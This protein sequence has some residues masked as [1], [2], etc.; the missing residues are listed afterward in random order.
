MPKV[1]VIVPVYKV[2]KTLERCVE[3]VRNQ[4]LKDIEILLVDDGSPDDCPRM[5]DSFAAADARIKVIHRENGGLGRARNSGL[6]LASG[7]Y[8]GFVDS[9]DYIAPEMYEQLYRTATAHSADCVF[10]GICYVSEGEKT[11]SCFEE[12]T[13][14][15]EGEEGIRQ[16][17]HNRLASYPWEKEDSR[18]GSTVTNG[19]FRNALLQEKGIRFLSERD[20]S[21]EDTLFG[22]SF[23]ASA[24]VGVMI[25]GHYYFYEY[26]PK[27]LSKAY[28]PRRYAGNVALY[29]YVT[30]YLNKRYPDSTL[31]HDYQRAFLA[32][33][34]VCAIQ[35][36]TAGNG[37]K[38]LKAISR[39]ETLSKLLKEYDW[40]KLP[41][42]KR[43]FAFCVRYRLDVL[44]YLG[45]YLLK[46]R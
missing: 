36:V 27:S 35:E 37:I 12:K 43:F 13:T 16:L 32:A 34:R 15:F 20:Y 21:S 44:T 18:Y 11:Y 30:D 19:I 4:T 1:S 33:A 2:E 45:I 5:C 3:S 10:C 6:D 8:V 46:K 7:E 22:M 31:A 42:K 41:L 38:G 40:R 26:N 14:C 39:D 29:R 24:K 28:N 23:L 17:Q 25:E 9:D